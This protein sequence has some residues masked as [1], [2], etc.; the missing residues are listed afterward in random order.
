MLRELI[1]VDTD[2]VRSLL[3]QMDGGVAEDIRV[4][5]K[6]QGR[7]SGGMRNVASR[8]H[9]WGSEESAQRSLADAVFPTLE[10]A[11]TVEGY[12][13]DISHEL[14]TG[15]PDTFE[16]LMENHPPGSVVRI[17]APARLFDARYVAKAFAGFATAFQGVLQL[18]NDGPAQSRARNQKPGPSKSKKG[19]TSRLIT[20]PLPEAL[21]ELIE[22]YN[23]SGAIESIPPEQIRGFIKIARGVFHPGLHITMATAGMGGVSVTARLQEGRRFLDSEPEILFA[24]Y[25]LHE[26]DWT[27]VGTIGSYAPPPG[28]QY[29]LTDITREDGNVSRRKIVQ[30]VNDLLSLLGSIGFADQP[31]YPGL[32]IVPLA[33]YRPILSINRDELVPA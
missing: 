17:S 3:S 20:D 10:E 8:E 5:E 9:V 6:K 28:Y 21:E 23:A 19:E 27:M 18:D 15:E 22:D 14:A 26:Q 25:G 1:Y 2:K 29:E 11:L 16:Q 33:V 31:E 12:L 32:S 24:R 7:M 13:A 4:T 30:S